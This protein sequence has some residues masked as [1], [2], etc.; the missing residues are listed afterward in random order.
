MSRYD[1]LIEHVARREEAITR[2]LGQ[3]RDALAACGRLIASYGEAR[4][5]TSRQQGEGRE[6]LRHATQVKNIWVPSG[7]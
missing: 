6:F 1:L 4:D 5:W 3:I 2:E 7:A